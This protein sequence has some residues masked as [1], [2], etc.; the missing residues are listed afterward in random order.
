MNPHSAGAHPEPGTP[1]RLLPGSSNPVAREDQAEQIARTILAGFEKHFSFF[2]E[3]TGGARERFERCDWQGIR[4]A[5]AERINLYDERVRET[6][7]KLR[8]TFAL[9]ALDEPL[10]IRVKAIY[11]ELLRHHQRPELCETFY[12][13]VFC[14]MFH[15]KYYHNDNIFVDSLADL[16]RLVKEYRAYLSFHPRDG[17]LETS[18]REILNAYYFKLPFEDFERDVAHIVEAFLRDSP[19]AKTPLDRLRI[20]ML[21]TPFYRN[22]GAYLIGRVVHGDTRLPFVIPVMNN[23]HGGLYCDALLTTGE[24][25]AIIFSFARGYFLVKTP[26]PSATVAFL[27]GLM[28]NKGIAE[29]YMSIGFHKQAKN[30]FYRDFLHH[31][32]ATDDPFEIAPGVRGMVMSVFTMP[33]FPYVFK[34]I[35]DRFAPPKDTTREAVKRCYL[36]VKMHDRIGRMADTLEYSEVAFPRDRFSPELLEELT[37]HAPSLLEFEDDVIII[38]HVY[39]ERRMRPLNLFLEET[40]PE[41]ARAAIDDWGLA[42]K[43]LMSVNIFP[44]DLLFKNFGVTRHGR[45]VFYDYDEISYLTDCNFRKLP[46]PMFPED[47]LSAE[48]GFSVGPRDV[49]PEE[50]ATFITTDPEHRRMLRETHPELLDYRYW[51]ERQ[52]DIQD[53][54]Q[55]DVFPYPAEVRFPRTA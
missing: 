25:L 12:N 3:I 38:R 35:K 7:G 18:V 37:E 33:S 32:E 46:E 51:Q 6:I 27:K 11:V 43:E 9:E 34:V 48:P 5:S 22:K 15:R 28:A 41:E 30:E 44:G 4:E 31:L 52:E 39:I 23:E 50:F 55:A 20:D 36:L 16:E 2:Q 13:S 47:E 29:I 49:F 40:A 21:D 54:V 10:W 17:G 24:H 42:I 14:Q 26:V 1:D 19:L 45:V 53:G 8:M